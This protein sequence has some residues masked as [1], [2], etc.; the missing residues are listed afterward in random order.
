M[1]ISVMMIT[2]GMLW[3][4]TGVTAGVFLWRDDRRAPQWAVACLVFFILFAMACS[5]PAGEA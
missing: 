4:G 3:L 1:F 5:V 2:F